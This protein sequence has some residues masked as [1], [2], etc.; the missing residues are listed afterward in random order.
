LRKQTEFKSSDLNFQISGSQT[1]KLIKRNISNLK[2]LLAL[3]GHSNLKV[4]LCKD[5]TITRFCLSTLQHSKW[6]KELKTF[7]IQTKEKGRVQ[8]ETE[9]EYKTAIQNLGL[10]ISRFLMGNTYDIYSQDVHNLIVEPLDKSLK[11]IAIHG[12][13][14]DEHLS[15]TFDTRKDSLEGLT[16]DCD[17]FDAS[18]SEKLGVW[19]KKNYNFEFILQFRQF[20]LSSTA[21]TTYNIDPGHGDLLGDT[22]L[23]FTTQ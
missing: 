18:S 11:A 1:S 6:W 22:L 20:K 21:E 10:Q 8:S 3:S 7:Q 23:H 16:L 2:I 15:S 13:P 12:F 19:C 17:Y 5:L 14:T 9:K 4:L